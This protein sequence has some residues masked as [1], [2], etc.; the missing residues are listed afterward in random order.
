MAGEPEDRILKW[1]LLDKASD[2]PPDQEI[3]SPPSL[4]FPA[5]LYNKLSKHLN[6]AE[7]TPISWILSSKF[8]SDGKR[9]WETNFLKR[10]KGG[11]LLSPQVQLFLLIHDSISFYWVGACSSNKHL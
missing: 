8:E 1:V 6:I 3:S 4:I 2:S 9:R 5:Y 7:Y 10:K 11:R